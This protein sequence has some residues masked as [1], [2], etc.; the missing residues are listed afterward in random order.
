MSEVDREDLLE[1]QD[2]LQDVDGLTGV[3]RPQGPTK[4]IQ[5]KYLKGGDSQAAQI[6][7]ESMMEDLDLELMEWERT[8]T[9]V[10]MTFAKAGYWHIPDLW[11]QGDEQDD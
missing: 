5:V 8:W 11:D 10:K 6:A 2:T 9:A 7:I 4:V 3:R 1:W